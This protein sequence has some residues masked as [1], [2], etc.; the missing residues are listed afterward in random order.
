[1]LRIDLNLIFLVLQKGK[2]QLEKPKPM[3]KKSALT[4]K[5]NSSSLN[6]DVLPPITANPS[7]KVSSHAEN[8][9][10]ATAYQ[11]TFDENDK[12]KTK[13]NK[14]SAPLNMIAPTRNAQDERYIKIEIFSTKVF[15][16]NMRYNSC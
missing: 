8:G 1:M 11:V 3:E 6:K 14:F 5:I 16:F 13:K 7:R 9:G 12:I 4:A 2:L 10:N 15:K